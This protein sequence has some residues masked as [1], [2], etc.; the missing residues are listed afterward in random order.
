MGQV[1]QCRDSTTIQMH[2]LMFSVECY[3]REIRIVETPEDKHPRICLIN[4]EEH[5][6]SNTEFIELNTDHDF[7]V[8][9][10]ALMSCVQKD[11]K[12]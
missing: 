5:S 2:H 12:Q 3:N 11:A 8:V 10:D 7:N 9:W 1:P 6:K 4:F